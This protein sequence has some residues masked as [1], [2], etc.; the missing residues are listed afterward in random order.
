MNIKIIESNN[1]TFIYNVM[2]LWRKSMIMRIR[3]LM[4]SFISLLSLFMRDMW[5]AVEE[6]GLRKISMIKLAPFSNWLLFIRH[7]LKTLEKV[8][9]C[10]ITLKL[11][12]RSIIDWLIIKLFIFWLNFVI[13]ELR[14]VARYAFEAYFRFAI[15]GIWTLFDFRRTWSMKIIFIGSGII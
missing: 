3:L 6:V 8:F 5:W 9:I 1:N 10:W 13:L 7:H 2:L 11:N 4:W 12:L 15:L 14:F